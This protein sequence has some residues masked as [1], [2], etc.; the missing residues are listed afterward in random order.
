MLCHTNLCYFDGWPHHLTPT[1]STAADQSLPVS[2]LNGS[3]SNDDV[4][5]SMGKRN[6]RS[7]TNETKLHEVVINGTVHLHLETG[8]RRHSDADG[9]RKG[10]EMTAPDAAAHTND[11]HQQQQLQQQHI[12]ARKINTEKYWK[13]YRNYMKRK[14]TSAAVEP[15]QRTNAQPRSSAEPDADDE[16]HIDDA[17]SVSNFTLNWPIMRTGLLFSL[18]YAV[19]LLCSIQFLLDTESA[20][21]TVA[22]MSLALPLAGIFWSLFE[23]KTAEHIGMYGNAPHAAAVDNLSICCRLCGW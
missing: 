10:I 8:R 5:Q 20:V 12:L 16:A 14:R 22:V 1:V 23:L 11:T 19:F 17:E 13:K 21:F 3:T 18:F 2:M 9:N 7:L 4:P 6:R 15:A